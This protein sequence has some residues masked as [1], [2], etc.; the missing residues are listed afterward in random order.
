MFAS[1]L[2]FGTQ[3]AKTIDLKKHYNSASVADLKYN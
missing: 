3:F 2:K 1:Y